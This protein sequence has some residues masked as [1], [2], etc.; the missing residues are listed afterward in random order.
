[1]KARLAVLGMIFCLAAGAQ[2][3]TVQ[4]LVRMV[5]SSIELHHKDGE[6]AK[7]LKRVKLTEKLDAATMEELAAL[8]AGSKTLKALAQLA[9]ESARLPD[10]RPVEVRKKKPTV[11]PPSP[12]EQDRIINAVRDFA[13]GYLKGLPDFICTQ[14]TRRYADPSGMGFWHKIDTVTA[15]LTYFDQKEDYKVILVNN[16]PVNLTMD[17]VQGATSSGEFG[18]LMR[19][20][21]DPET[22]ASFQWERWGKLRG[23]ICHVYNYYVR[24]EKSKWSISYEKKM[25]TIPAYRGLIYVDR[26]TEM[27]IRIT[28]EALNIDPSFPVQEA[29]TVLDYDFVKISGGEYMLPL[30]FEM[31]MRQGRFLVKNEVEFRLYRK[32]GAEAVINFD[33]PESLP[34]DMF[35]EEPAEPKKP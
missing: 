13:L 16:R 19:E 7:Y 9:K 28:L 32:F 4:Q 6:V 1:M 8:G 26:D 11:P 20:I 31:R 27:V 35:A 30:K 10:P 3:I 18:T 33:T 24:K 2:Q 14:V 5:R 15:K 17:D 23:R 22:D 25:R 34:D 21:F 12:A 29:R